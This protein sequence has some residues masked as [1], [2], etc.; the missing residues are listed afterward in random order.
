MASIAPSACLPR[1]LD[2]ALLIGR[3][4]RAAPVDGPSVVAVRRGEVFDI[5]SS[6]PTTADLFDRAD[7]LDIARNAPGESL[8]RVE[9]L[10]EGALKGSS[11]AVQLLAP[12]DVQ[13]IKAC[14]VTFA[15]SLL[16]RVIEEQAGGDASKAEEVRATIHKLI[17]ADLRRSSRGRK[18]RR[19]SRPSSNGAARGRNTWR[20]ASGRMRRC[21]RSRNRCR[22][23]GSERVLGCIRC[24]SGTIR[25]RR[26]CWR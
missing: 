8:G 9:A 1:D 21:S 24:R 4:W 10:I 14:G 12:C 18:Q 26:S 25:S 16:E 13:A 15:V 6:A 5:T 23:W 17:G 20:S 22:R 3:V 11:S 19:R 7:M 2:D